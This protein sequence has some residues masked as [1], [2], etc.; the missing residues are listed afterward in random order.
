MRSYIRKEIFRDGWNYAVNLSSSLLIA[1][2]TALRRKTS[3]EHRRT[4]MLVFLR[5][6]PETHEAGR[7]SASVTVNLL[8]VSISYEFSV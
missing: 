3:P 4:E 7:L 2:Q 5:N 1:N 8:I 6:C